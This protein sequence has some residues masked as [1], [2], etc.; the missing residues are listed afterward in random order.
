MKVLFLVLPIVLIE[1]KKSGPDSS[2]IIN[3][4]RER[5]EEEII[6]GYIFKEN[7][8]VEYKDNFENELNRTEE[9]LLRMY[10]INDSLMIELYKC[11]Q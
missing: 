3:E 6:N 9:E 4:E 11:Q 7:D 1:C 8:F 2:V 10:E 5:M